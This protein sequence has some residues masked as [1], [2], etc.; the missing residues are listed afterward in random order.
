MSLRDAA[1]PRDRGGATLR[2]KVH[3][4]T[5][6]RGRK[7]LRKGAGPV[8]K[9]DAGRVPRIS[10]LMALAIHYDELIRKGLDHMEQPTPWL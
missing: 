2:E 7:R 3:F 4:R 8:K 1:S 6:S 9:T 5:G 10:R